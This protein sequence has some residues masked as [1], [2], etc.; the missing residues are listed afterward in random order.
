MNLDKCCM[1]NRF[2]SKL[3]ILGVL[4]APLSA[5]ATVSFS[6]IMYD[7]PGTDTGREWVEIHNDDATPVDIVGWKFLEAGVNHKL[8]P[9]QGSVIPG[10]GYAVIAGNA[11]K[12]LSDNKDFSGLL[13]Q[14]SFSLSNTGETLVL[15]DASSTEVASVTY[16]SN[17]G[18]DGNSLNYVGA[19][20]V[21]R[22]A[23]PGNV[24]SSA[25]IAPK[26]QASKLGNANHGSKVSTTD[27]AA[28]GGA[29]SNTATAGLYT[30]MDSKG[31][32]QSFAMLPWVAA[33]FAII[34]IAGAA[35]FLKRKDSP[36][37]GYTITEEK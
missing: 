26:P 28:T 32:E 4:C 14:S 21:V 10:F 12:F 25:K 1:L 34:G 15:K 9:Q 7:V 36:K 30:S 23:S 37:S 22:S 20:W 29:V 11:E 17:D 6:E 13:F 19:S 2:R 31:A 33:L 27:S 5:F 35:I 8:V 18:G 16:T 3:V 24:P